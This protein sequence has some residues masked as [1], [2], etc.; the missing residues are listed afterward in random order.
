MPPAAQIPVSASARVGLYRSVLAE[1]RVLIVLDN[2]RND[3][4]VRPLLA[5]GPGC[6]VVVTSRSALTSLVASDGARPVQ[7]SPLDADEAWQ[8]LAARL[9]RERLASEPVAV[10]H[11]LRVCGGLPLALAITA[12]RAA[13]TPGLTL[14]DLAERLASDADRLDA[15]DTGDEA[16]TARTVF[17][18]SFQQLS[19]SAARL[20]GLG[21]HGGPD[22]SLPAAASLAALPPGAARRAL[23]ELAD[24]S[25]VAQHR[26]GRYL[27]HDLLRSYA[28][29]AGLGHRR[30]T[31][32]VADLPPPG[33]A[34]GSG[35]PLG[36]LRNVRSDRT[37]CG[38]ASSRLRRTRP[39]PSQSRHAIRNPRRQDR[40][41]SPQ[42]QVAGVLPASG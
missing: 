28:A 34:T 8:V 29:R 11:L 1:R 16:T 12:A 2:A 25:L 35:R 39:G 38:N 33:G 3:A 27:L 22:I 13:V 24:A 18:W 37:G 30:L 17:S 32:S 4:Q 7:L 23:A 26:P 20:F 9:G 41:R 21:V 42:P 31:P 36:G 19:E 14:A 15:L 5:G 6:L 40:S 10:T